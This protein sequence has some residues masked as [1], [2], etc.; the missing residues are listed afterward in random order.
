MILIDQERTLNETYQAGV[1]YEYATEDLVL[2]GYASPAAAVSALSGATVQWVVGG[3]TVAGSITATAL[4][5][6]VA[7]TLTIWPPTSL[8]D[9][10]QDVA[11]RIVIEPGSPTSEDVPV[12]GR[13]IVRAYLA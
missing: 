5:D 3:T 6:G 12:Q 7:V 10:A 4:A 8:T 11:Y 1:Y 9:V 13:W 2:R